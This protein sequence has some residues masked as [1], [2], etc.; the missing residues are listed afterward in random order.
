VAVALVLVASIAVSVPSPS[1][2][3]RQLPNFAGKATGDVNCDKTTS[4][5][6]VDIILEAAV[7]LRTAAK[8]CPLKDPATQ[9]DAS[10]ADVDGNGIVDVAD[11]LLVAECVERGD[12]GCERDEDPGD[13][14]EDPGPFDPDGPQPAPAPIELVL[15]P[16]A[17]PFICDGVEGI[18]PT[19]G[20]LRGFLPGE[21]VEI[22]WDSGRRTNDADAQGT[23]T[24]QW[25]CI[26]SRARSLTMVA[27]G[28]D[29][30]RSLVFDFVTAS[31]PTP[32]LA[33]VLEHNPFVC[34]G[35]ADRAPVAGRISGFEPNEDVLIAWDRGAT[36]VAADASGVRTFRWECDLADV[37]I[38]ELT[39]VGTTSNRSV[40]FPLE[41]VAPAGNGD[42]L[43]NVLALLL[44]VTGTSLTDDER[45]QLALIARA[46]SSPGEV[47]DGGNV[48]Q[49][50]LSSF[51]PGFVCYVA[52]RWPTER[53]PSAAVR[54]DLLDAYDCASALPGFNPD[55]DRTT[56]TGT[57]G[58]ICTGAENRAGRV[59]FARDMQRLFPGIDRLGQVNCRE[60]RNPQN[61]S[62]TCQGVENPD[63][64]TCWS[65]HADG[66]GVDL[67]VDDDRAT[68]DATV[69]YILEE[70]NGIDGF[71]ARAM[72]VIQIIWFDRCWGPPNTYN[73]GAVASWAEMR[74][75]GIAAHQD[76]P[77]VTLAIRAAE[78]DE[79]FPYYAWRNDYSAFLQKLFGSILP[80]PAA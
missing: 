56:S 55:T 3:A 67:M 14:D 25:E 12:P 42:E 16:F 73:D 75:C 39:A 51:V 69:E 63:F 27:T 80:R 68:G 43:S 45:R 17:Q 13:G 54:D 38:A 9:F 58:E 64:S 24:F 33:V 52:T 32:A 53:F 62:E 40:T 41:M 8:G 66:R 79:D 22:Q 57:R 10:N 48:L 47:L 77:H 70:I 21:P 76:H 44:E 78:A 19:V 29:S 71:R 50:E 61:P 72:G 37:R 34:T 28:L 74:R 11:A 59:A 60:I 18:A 65:T 20:E 6:D 26:P 15:A 30:G 49:G 1:V 23:R 5:V 36:T 7:S 2:E 4:R 46:G 35:T 31:E